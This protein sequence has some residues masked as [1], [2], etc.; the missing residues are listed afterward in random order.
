MD[1]D[2]VLSMI[3]I[4][5]I[6]GG[7]CLIIGGVF[8]QAGDEQAH[9]ACIEQ[10]IPSDTRL[11]YMYGI[12]TDLAVCVVQEIELLDLDEFGVVND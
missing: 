11:T 1:F 3:I 9:L 8:N 12:H 4:I 7:L 5:L 2:D 6:V 10:G